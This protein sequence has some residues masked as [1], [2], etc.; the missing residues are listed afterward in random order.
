[1]TRSVRRAEFMYPAGIASNGLEASMQA[2]SFLSEGVD[3]TLKACPKSII[4]VR[5][6]FQDR[7]RASHGLVVVSSD[8]DLA[9]CWATRGPQ[10]VALSRAHDSISSAM[11]LSGSPGPFSSPYRLVCVSSECRVLPAAVLVGRD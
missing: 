4:E 5:S 8:S 7:T 1:M 2:A 6:L 3:T 9:S 10:A 11:G